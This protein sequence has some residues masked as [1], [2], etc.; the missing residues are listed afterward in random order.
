MNFI[1]DIKVV[2]E[3]LKAFLILQFENK[4]I[5]SK[6]MD[7]YHFQTVV[8]TQACLL[9]LVLVQKN[10]LSKACHILLILQIK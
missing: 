3:T 5:I 4:K 9:T 2:N 10:S 1:K 7:N 8:F 6:C